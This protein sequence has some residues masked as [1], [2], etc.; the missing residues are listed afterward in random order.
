MRVP[1]LG[2]L[3]FRVFVLFMAHTCHIVNVAYNSLFLGEICLPDWDMVRAA[4][5][6]R[7]ALRGALPPARP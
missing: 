4:A 7:R 6:C 2:L 5:A 3:G 1:F